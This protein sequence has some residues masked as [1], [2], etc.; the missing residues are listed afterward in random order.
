MPITSAV[1]VSLEQ[2]MLE[3]RRVFISDFQVMMS[4]GAYDVERRALQRVRLNIEVFV[5]LVLCTPTQ[6]QL[7]EVFD[8]D[9]IH[10][11]MIARTSVHTNLQETLCDDIARRLLAHDSV[12]AVRVRS[13]KLDAYRDCHAAGVEVLL[14][15]PKDAAQA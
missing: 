2:L 8:Y 9:L 4:I 7:G 15:K 1:H 6:D 12:R 10:E 14:V 3:C 5:P 11:A 13:E